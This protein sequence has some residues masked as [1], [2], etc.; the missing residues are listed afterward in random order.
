MP[1]ICCAMLRRP[2]A[3]VVAVAPWLA[4]LSAL[5]ISWIAEPKGTVG[6]VGVGG[7]DR[8]VGLHLGVLLQVGPQLQQRVD[9]VGRVRCDV[10]LLAGGDLV[11]GLGDALLD[12][13]H[14][15]DKQRGLGIEVGNHGG[16]QEVTIS[17]L[18]VSSDNWSRIVISFE[19]AS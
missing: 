9:L 15:G 8:Q 1:W 11:V 19:L 16:L 12:A 2:E 13:I 10:D 7:R 4:R 14:V 17:M 18:M 3:S 6:G 5:S